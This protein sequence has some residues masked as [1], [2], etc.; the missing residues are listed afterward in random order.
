MQLL[1]IHMTD[2][3]TRLIF[4]FFFIG[5]AIGGTLVGRFCF[6][7][8]FFFYLLSYVLNE[9]ATVEM[10]QKCNLGLK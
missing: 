7:V 5:C 10:T 3:M 1:Y 9:N 8:F 6:I 2:C 4:F